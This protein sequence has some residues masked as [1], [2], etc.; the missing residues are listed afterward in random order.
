MA[1]TG[2]T[3]LDPSRTKMQRKAFMREMKKRFALMWKVLQ[4]FLVEDDAFGL[5]KPEPLKLNE[6]KQDK[7][8]AESWDRLEND[9]LVAAVQ[10]G[11][12]IRTGV[13]RN[14]RR[15]Y[16][17]LT[18]PQKLR[19]FQ[20]WLDQQVKAGLLQ[21]TGNQNKP[22]TS[23][24]VESA[25]RKGMVRAY[26]DVHRGELAAKLLW[27]RGTGEQFVMDAF[28]QP[29]LMSKVELLATRA[30]EGMKGVTATMSTQ[31]SR[32]LA[33]G[34]SRG[35]GPAEIARQMR[36]TISTLSSDRAMTIARTE[37]IHAHAEG[38]LDGYKLLGID[39]V[40]AEVEWS[41]AGD[42]LVCEQCEKAS[43]DEDGNIRIYTIDEARGKI[44]LHPN[45]RCAWV[46]VVPEL[47]KEKK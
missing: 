29:E 1:K 45:C 18:T 25:W 37:I 12:E 40:S 3:K 27:Y 34:M 28:L 31:M 26:T 6:Q 38:Q 43:E 17:F 30:F 44:P 9:I 46:S 15:Q 4:K 20:N 36:K 22:W 39:E 7:L 13:V 23:T 10:S 8:S 11:A 47:K 19:Q 21:V 41:T 32:I 2:W 24:Y 5:E 33:D 14:I 16:Q 42:E 35:A